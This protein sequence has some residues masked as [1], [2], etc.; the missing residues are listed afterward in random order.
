MV[1]SMKVTMNTER[2]MEQEPLSG[3]MVQCT[4]E[5]STTTTSMERESILGVMVENTRVS[6]EVIKC[7][8]KAHLPGLMEGD[9][10]ENM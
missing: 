8:A 1:L 6:G 3:L 7:M 2:S 5:S 10:L 9:M 4:L